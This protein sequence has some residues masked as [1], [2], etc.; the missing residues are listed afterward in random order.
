[1]VSKDLK[2]TL[3]A[4]PAPGKIRWTTLVE[5]DIPDLLVSNPALREEDIRRWAADGQECT[6]ARLGPTLVHYLWEASRPVYLPYLGRTLKLVDGD[7]CTTAVFTHPAF[8]N[9]GLYAASSVRALHEARRRGF[10]RMLGLA[11]WWNAPALHVMQD[12]AG[13]H[14]VGVVGYW[15]LG[16]WRLLYGRG[17]VRLG[18]DITLSV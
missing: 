10:V 6:V 3:P 1:M 12:I 18:E 13:R 8:R 15:Q 9:R 2:G 16:P 4:L 14:V 5:A 17:G 11:E 7:R